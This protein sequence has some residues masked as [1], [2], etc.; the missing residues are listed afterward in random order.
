MLQYPVWTEDFFIDM[1][2]FKTIEEQI[3]ILKKRGLTFNNLEDAKKILLMNNYYNVI[4][5]YKEPFIIQGTKDNFLIG[6]TFEEIFALYNFDKAIKD[7]FLEYILKLENNLR[8]LISYYFSMFHGNDN[9]LTFYDFDDL[10]KV[11]NTTVEKRQNRIRCIQD[12]IGTIHKE[13]VRTIDSKAYI[14]HYMLDYGFVPPWV[15]VNILS[16]GKLSKFLELMQQKERILISQQYNISENELIQCVKML[17]YFRNLC[18]HDDRIYNTK[19]PKYLY[20]PDNRYH[21]KLNISKKNNMYL[22]GKNDLFALVLVLK[23]MLNEN[24]FNT[25]YNKIY[26]RIKSLEKKL[27]V[28][29]IGSILNIMNFPENWREIKKF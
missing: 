1:K 27:F 26:G 11:T 24:D 22:Y 12:L 8:S 17:A 10:S 6:T 28:I 25:L 16:F 3:D 7:I 15:L 13:I 2:E 5:G 20:I 14:N 29:S 9:Y 23:I 19:V 4:N 18:A 21:S